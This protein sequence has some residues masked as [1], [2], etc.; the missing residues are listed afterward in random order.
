MERGN[1]PKTGIVQRNSAGR[2]LPGVSPNPS[3]RPKSLNELAKI[4]QELTPEVIE[5][6][7]GVVRTGRGADK[8]S[9]G[10]LLIEYGYGRPFQAVDINVQTTFDSP[11]ARQERIRELQQQLEDPDASE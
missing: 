3:G 2:W 1:T 10:R 6:L 9:A 4:C 11:E 7:M 5:S 8:V